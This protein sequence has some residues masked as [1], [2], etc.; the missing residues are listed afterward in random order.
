MR[1]AA[2][3]R[4]HRLPGPGLAAALVSLALLAACATTAPRLPVIP[5]P[6][7]VAQLIATLSQREDSLRTVDA[8]FQID[9]RIDGIRQ[10]GSGALFWRQGGPLKLDVSDRLLGIGVLS[11]LT[12]H[13]SLAVY[14][15]R[16]NRFL[17]GQAADVL[18]TIT[19]VDVSYYDLDRA[20]LGIPNLAAADTGRVTRFETRSDTLHVE[21]LDPLWTR[22]LLF[23]AST[24]VLLEERVTTPGGAPLSAR[25]LSDYRIAGGVPLPRTIR[26]RQG[27]DR[28]TLRYNR[29]DVNTPLPDARFR[30][31]LPSDA[32]DLNRAD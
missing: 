26:I 5:V 17:Q 24:G 6:R 23:H 10:K 18:Y 29:R 28:I 2:D 32:L 9:L 16:E 11:A 19:G 14:L 15:P 22:N 30:L 1:R 20:V 25:R 31:N 13:D 27:D 4:A 3:A 8:R 12:S 21:I 7:N